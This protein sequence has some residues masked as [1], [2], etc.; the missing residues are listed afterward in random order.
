[1]RPVA[2]RP[3]VPLVIGAPRTGF[4]LCI[5]VL[6][7][8]VPLLPNK[9]DL[10]QAV[11]DHVGHYLDRYISTEIIKVFDQ[12][13]MVEDLIF[14]GNF[15]QMLGGPKWLREGDLSRC[16]V[17]K[18]IGVRG[19]GDFTLITSHP[20]EVMDRDNIV[21]SHEMPDVWPT[22]P[23]YDSY[24]KFA[25][26]RN[27][28]GT[29]NSSCFS[30]N[31]L[32][33]EYIQRFVSPEDDN[34]V[35]RQRLAMY[36]FTDM[37]FFDGLISYLKR[38]SD[39]FLESHHHYYKMRWED[40]IEQPLETIEAL[41]S[42]ANLAIDRNVSEKIWSNINHKNLTQFHKHNLRKG[43]GTVGGWRQWLTNHH[44]ERIKSHGFDDF[45]EAFGYGP[46]EMLV[47]SR[48]T[49]FQR[50]VDQA[51]RRNEQIQIT[52]DE[53]LFGFAFNKSNLDSTKFVFRRHD[54]RPETRV[55]RS[56]FADEDLEM[57][58]WDAAETACGRVNG[59]FSAVIES[60]FFERESAVASLDR[61]ERHFSGSF[62]GEADAA[63]EA[64]WARVRELTD[65]YFTRQRIAL[66]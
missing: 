25:S 1:M 64:A 31:A 8:F 45:L 59:L 5:N 47:E 24:I 9:R 30:I 16:C 11:L 46:I 32:T 43:A 65:A 52:E 29:L 58:V 34:D 49:E 10:K 36:K 56:C 35:L 62:G 21:H 39:K 2:E 37:D 61:I 38:Y 41:A 20:I 17:R 51:L 4:S 28:V 48:Y 63:F 53:D 6:H 50:E 12:E 60:R 40:L 26:V 66:P 3:F 14:N 33:S 44:L 27:P 42:H 57:R 19:K 13:G 23:H 22:V 15:Q 7:H 55:E 54:W 18:Y